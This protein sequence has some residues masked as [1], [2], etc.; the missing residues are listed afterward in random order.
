MTE[1][2]M[3]SVDDRV[4]T[5]F[6]EQVKSAGVVIAVMTEGYQHSAQCRTEAML[7]KQLGKTLILLQVRMESNTTKTTPLVQRA[8]Q[9][10]IIVLLSSS[11]ASTLRLN[12]TARI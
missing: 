10:L 9:L 2:G 11:S 3:R 6:Q 8:P 5:H 1:I 12:A 4:R 7:A